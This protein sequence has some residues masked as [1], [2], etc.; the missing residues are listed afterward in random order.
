LKKNSKKNRAGN[1]G[2]YEISKLNFQISEKKFRNLNQNFAFRKFRIFESSK[3]E[4]NFEI[5]YLNFEI[6]KFRKI[7]FRNFLF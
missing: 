5:F 4:N 3:L 7:D 6:F 1:F 2:Q